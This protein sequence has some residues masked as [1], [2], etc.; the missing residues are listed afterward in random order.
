MF[1]KNRGDGATGVLTVPMWPSLSYFGSL[2]SML[3]DQL[4]FFKATRTTLMNPSVG[5]LIY[6][7]RVTLLVC[8]VSGNRLSSVSFS[9]QVAD[10]SLSSWRKNTV[11]QYNVYLEKVFT[12]C[13]SRQSH[14]M[15]APVSLI[16]GFV[17]DLYT[18]GYGYS[19]LNTARSAI[20]ALYNTNKTDVGQNIGKHPLICRFLK[21]VFNESPS[22][23][24]EISGSMA[25]GKG[26][27]LF[28]TIYNSSC[29]KVEG[30][31]VE[32]GHVYCIS[33]LDI[34]MTMPNVDFFGYFER[35][36]KKNSK[37]TSPFSLS[38]HLKQTNRSRVWQSAPF[39]VPG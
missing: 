13:L 1:P 12:F 30:T 19:S 3:V 23:D 14:F 36:H 32:I 27:C 21:G 20:S 24:S 17:Y 37:H 38:G 18:K 9:T 4:L 15:R 34:V 5:E 25:C 22:S 6:P 7:L 28:R 35:T 2:L 8:R 33:N 10:G 39:S 16:L 31:Y 29:I 11:K 26:A